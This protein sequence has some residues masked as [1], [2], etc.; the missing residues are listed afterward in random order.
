MINQTT[1]QLAVPDVVRVA[2]RSK[3]KHLQQGFFHDSCSDMHLS[4]LSFY[5]FFLDSRQHFSSFKKMIEILPQSVHQHKI[6]W[7]KVDKKVEKTNCEKLQSH[8][9]GQKTNNCFNT[10]FIHHVA[11]GAHLFTSDGQL[12]PSVSRWAFQHWTEPNLI[13]RYWMCNLSFAVFCN[14]LSFDPLQHTLVVFDGFSVLF[15]QLLRS[16]CQSAQIPLMGCVVVW[17]NGLL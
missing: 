9:D 3:K 12:L 7:T 4:N 15:F 8:L 11:L 13:F 17:I 10:M 1:A 14:F 16:V 2:A 5:F 6:N